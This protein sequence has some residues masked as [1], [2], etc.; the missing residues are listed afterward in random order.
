MTTRLNRD[1][2]VAMANIGYS[3]TSVP[4]SIIT[5]D[6]IVVA[7]DGFTLRG[8]WFLPATIDP[9]APVV[10][11]ACG[12]GIPAR[13]YSR[14]AK[15]LAG[16]G[17]AALTFDYRGIGESRGSCFKGL[18]A[19]VE[20]WAQLDLGAAL[21]T[22][23]A[24]FPLA[25][26][27]M[28]AHSVGALLIGAA[29]DAHKVSRLVLFGP[30]TGYWRDYRPR[31]RWLLFLTWHVLMPIVTKMVGYF[32]GR[33]LRL[34]EDL[35]RA[36]ALD[37]AGRRRPGLLRTASDVRRFG[38]ILARYGQMRAQTLILS[39]TDDAFAPPV[40]AH[41]L[42]SLYPNLAA[43]HETIAPADLGHRRLGHMAFLRR[44]TGFFFWERAAAWLLQTDPA[45]RAGNTGVLSDVPP[46]G[47]K[48]LSP[49]GSATPS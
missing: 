4:D 3:D 1:A 24:A 23:R 28:I 44:P 31:W 38:Q 11:I 22:A 13:Y 12:G 16:K 15:F 25:S 40:A 36:F 9:S 49:A 21:S 32:P 18:E 45:G 39:V 35:P 48:G 33:A 34:G 30:H 37:W 46:S 29:P 43:V 8:K 42:L 19:G 20:T 6:I 5:R 2:P 17:M 41:R 10:V 47:T 14:M 26:L 27:G 7:A